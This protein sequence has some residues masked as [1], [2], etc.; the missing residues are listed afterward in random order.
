MFYRNS[1]DDAEV[2]R[3]ELVTVQKLM[4]QLSLEKEKEIEALNNKL[5]D[6]QKQDSKPDGEF[7]EQFSQISNEVKTLKASKLEDNQTI[8]SCTKELSEK[9]AKIS[10]LQ[11]ESRSVSTEVVI[12]T[13]ISQII[14]GIINVEC[15]CKFSER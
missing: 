13:I 15:L 12:Q 8:E 4:N 14:R 7:L 9:A 2:L 10:Q 11:D 3:Q 1:V 6:V 5:N